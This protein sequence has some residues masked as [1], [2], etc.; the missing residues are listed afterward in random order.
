MK[1]N[2]TVITIYVDV[3]AV[4]PHGTVA[5][6]IGVDNAGRRVSFLGDGRM[7]RHIAAEL[8]AGE[9][10]VRASVAPWQ[11]VPNGLTVLP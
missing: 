5:I 4:E 11:L 7:M 1:G 9:P 8:E 10:N 3:E 6:G 2:N